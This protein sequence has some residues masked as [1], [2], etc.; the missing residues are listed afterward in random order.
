MVELITPVETLPVRRTNPLPASGSLPHYM[1]GTWAWWSMV[2]LQWG[3]MSATSPA[4]VSTICVELRV[5]RRSLTTDASH[6]L[7]RA[8]V[9]SR[10]DYCNS[11][12]AGLPQYS[13]NKLQSILR[14]S[15]WLVLKLPGSASVSDL[16]RD[17]LHWLPVPL[18]IQFKLCCTVFKCLHGA[19]PPYLSEFC[20]PLSS[21]VGRYQLRSAAAGDLLIHPQN[22]DDWASRI[23][24]IRPSCLE[25]SSN[26]LE[27]S[28]TN[29]SG[30]QETIETHFFMTMWTVVMRLCGDCLKGALQIPVSN[31]IQFKDQLW[32]CDQFPS[33]VWSD[34]SIHCS[35]NENTWIMK[36]YYK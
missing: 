23:F 27:R 10:L 30:L 15:A 20:Q 17:E 28:Y 31:S 1:S 26:K 11:V 5:V 21:L 18:R 8:L 16:M 33:Y 4:P 6:S 22:C 2:S 29:F 12:L 14:A 36:I 3:L 25:W 7:V 24:D 32:K 9:H 19:A 35:L 13:L 34:I